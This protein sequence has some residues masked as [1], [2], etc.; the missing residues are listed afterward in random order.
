MSETTMLFVWI[1]L[2]LI[3]TMV[4]MEVPDT[5]N[6]L[7]C[8]LVTDKWINTGSNFLYSWTDYILELNNETT[9]EVNDFTY[10]NHMIG[11]YYCYNITVDNGDGEKKIWE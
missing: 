5:H 9:M 7:Q 6:E 10:Y 8:D 4:V 11:D 1:P 3:L 2:A